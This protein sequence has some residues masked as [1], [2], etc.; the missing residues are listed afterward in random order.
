MNLS[1]LCIRRP[2]LTIVLNLAIVLFGVIGLWFLGVREYPN[3]DR[4]VISVTTNYTGANA[5]VIESQITEPLEE[6]ISGIDGIRQ[7]SSV[8][9]E[10][11]STITVEFELGVDLNDAANNVIEKVTRSQR[12]LPPDADP[13]VV[14]KEDGN[15][16]PIIFL[17]IRS[18]KRNAMEITEVADRIFKQQ[19]QTIQG[20]SLVPIWGSQL[21]SMRL[22]LSRERMA[23]QG[24]TPPD[25]LQ[26]L[27]RENVELPSGRVEGNSTELTVRTLGR[28]ET[29]EDFN[30]LPIRQDGL[31]TIR[32]RDIGY[33][34]LGAENQRT[35][36]KRDNIPMI[37]VGLIPQPG[38]NYLEI[39]N[40][41]YDR[42]NNI[43]RNLP[44]DIE[45]SIGFDSTTFIRKAVDEV[46]ETI[47][48]SIM[49]VVL[50]I[51]IFLR[52]WRTTLI[53][54]LA[55]PISLVGSFFVMFMLGFSI[56]ILTLLALVLAIGI[57]VDDAIVMME[58]IYA[59]IEEGETP[60]HAA[61]HG[62]AE[63]FFAVLSTTI[64]LVVV[65]L[66]L[67][68]IQGLVG[69]LFFEFGVVLSV[70]VIISGFVALTLTPMVSSRLLRPVNQQ[71]WL[72]RK[73]EPLF[74]A[75]NDGYGRWLEGFIRRPWL[76]PVILA[77]S[78]ILMVVMFFQLKSELS[79]LEDRSQVWVN[80]TAPEGATFEY[81]LR[82]MD[83]LTELAMKTVPESEREGVISVTSPGF[84]ATGSVNSGFMRLILKQP[85]DRSMKQGEIAKML[86]PL[87]S[88]YTGARTTVNEQ[89]TFG[90]RNAMPVE[91]VVKAP[92]NEELRKVL[93]PL[94][95]EARKSKY[96]AFVDVNLKLNKPEL[97]IVPDRQ[98]AR[99]LGVSVRDISQTLQMALSG[100]RYGYFIKNGKQ[101]QVI[102]QLERSD[103]N[104]PRDIRSLYVRNNRGE[105]VQLDNVVRTEETTT[106]P[107]L[108]RYER[109]PSATFVAATAPGITQSEGLEEMERIAK[110][111][112]PSSFQTA[113]AGSSKDFA[114]SNN[115]LFYSFALALVL[116]YLVLAAQF[117]SFVDPV[118][119]LLNVLT[120]LAGA[121]LSL[122]YFEQTLNI[123][124]QIGIIMLVGLVT[125]NGI[126][127]VEFANQRQ[128][129]GMDKLA[130]V[131]GAA[132]ARFRPI[133]MTTL[134]TLFGFLPIALALGAGAESRVSMGI[135]VVAGVA[136]SS[137]LSVFIVPGMYLLLSR[138]KAPK[139]QQVQA[140]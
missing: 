66:P 24:V 71:G 40:K 10:E 65:F 72:Y 35:L 81:M 113:Y 7:I 96:F 110:Q 127:I 123:F 58:N 100:N 45:I 27:E 15:N 25:V 84:S 107:A 137:F 85:E 55:I 108:Y 3:T 57:V 63:M 47:Y 119:I 78:G 53:P 97:T 117:E 61:I 22:W 29:E 50:I 134:A 20:V 86:T 44:E 112:L 129:Q 30:N 80:S 87:V 103:R 92:N 8:S 121:L 76:S 56:N 64:S 59:R 133:L 82:Y 69:R 2:V 41:F 91:F 31:R 9:R 102:G 89:Q 46:T 83:E 115:N 32:L 48:V 19:I 126:L 39:A 49:L 43:R 75:L 111:M 13:P 101:Y 105:L 77:A 21:Y 62:S 79:P 1:E 28:L 93:D 5:E 17:N 132:L 26:A 33:A 6:F 135:V 94:L 16:N 95:A 51:F 11:R 37:G 88:S 124:S 136:L 14:A 12:Q 54:V 38:A 131:Q 90:S 4:P 74:I 68:F 23:A 42:L 52:S 60:M 118:I 98:K 138:G 18:R 99:D 73:T 120:A 106:T 125:K 36:M 116:V 67:L 114:E 109:Y 104:D 140:L 34:Q 122:W 128:E 139:A 130:A 70:S